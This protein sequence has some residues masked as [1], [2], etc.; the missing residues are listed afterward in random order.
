M[1]LSR[2]PLLPPT[3][4]NV[5]SFSQI[6]T[7]LIIILF[8]SF[9][10]GFLFFFYFLSMSN[11]EVCSSSP[12]PCNFPEPSAVKVQVVPKSVS[13][14]L[15]DKFFDVSEYNFDYEKSG[16]WSPPVRRSVFLSSPGRIFTEQEMLERLRSVMDRR[17]SRR[18]LCFCFNV[19]IYMIEFISVS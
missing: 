15:L 14:R 19:C 4:K 12:P 17:P 18:R 3:L 11:S 10:E 5:V 13:D 16:I 6:P 7:L 9:L 1:S 2:F 8:F